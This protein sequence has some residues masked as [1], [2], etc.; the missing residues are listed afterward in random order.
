[1]SIN[2]SIRQTKRGPNIAAEFPDDAEEHKMR[3]KI[4]APVPIS[5]AYRRPFSKEPTWKNESENAHEK[6]NSRKNNSA[7][8]NASANPKSNPRKI[9]ILKVYGPARSQDK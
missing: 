8:S 1:M 6:R 5:A 9:P 2:E 7:A 3:R 4:A